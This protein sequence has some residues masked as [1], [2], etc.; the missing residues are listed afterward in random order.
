MKTIKEIL[1]DQETKVIDVRSSWEYEAGHIEGALNIP[2]DELPHQLETLKAFTGPIVVY[3][4][5][6]GR[7]SMAQQY[8]MQ[9]G[10]EEVHNGGGIVQM[11]ILTL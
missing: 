3:C 9:Q 2:V 6:G 7:S 8:L 4:Q 5:S 11:R 10:F 1:M